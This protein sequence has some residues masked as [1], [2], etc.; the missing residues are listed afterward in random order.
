MNLPKEIRDIAA[1]LGHAGYQAYLVGG[2][3]RDLLMDK[4][5]AD[6][7]MATN[8]K[9]EEVQK[10]FASFAGGE[11]DH[12]DTVYENTFGT[13]GIKTGSSDPR[14][15]VV[16]VTT[17]RTE[18]AY[19]DKRHPDDVHFAE[20]IEEDLARRDF[21]INAMALPLTNDL[22]LVTDDQELELIDPYG[23]QEDLKKKIIRAVGDPEKR[24]SEDALRL[25]RA[26]RFAAQ[27]GFVIE[28][29]TRVAIR[30]LAP[31][32][33][34]I[35]KERIRDEFMKL[36]VTERAHEGVRE[37]LSTGLL[38]EIIP[39][40]VVGVGVEQNQHH[41]YDVFEHN[42]RSLEYAVSQNYSIVVRLASLLHDVGKPKSRRWKASAKAK[43]IRNGVRGDYTFYGH[44][45]VGARQTEAIL[46][47]L[48]FSR[49]IIDR[50]TLLVREHMFIYDPEV[51]TLAGV[52]RL[53]ARVGDENLEDLIRLREA[54]RI[55][56]GV[57]KAQPY[58]L[59]YLQA[60]LEKVQSD[61]VSPK[62]LA[63][64]GDEVIRIA[65]LT[66]GPRVGW[67]ISVLLD[68]VLEDPTRNSSEVLGARVAELAKL[69][70][71]ELRT[72]SEKGKKKALQAQE[73]IDEEI[74]KKYFV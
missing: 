56:S 17:F 63:M 39:E 50:V 36:L 28:E 62:M 9:P 12:P 43:K 38:Q 73:K 27:L 26:V 61:P 25:L 52:R 59:R 32:I 60:M 72:L 10:L 20:T 5:P 45:V 6:W 71:A 24:F 29:K 48:H 40:L 54:D 18:S 41:I 67:I 22:R 46:T 37:F 1:V 35:A 64:K 55:G 66:P 13:I 15:A 2:S 74:K 65:N 47:R 49:E 3:L 19:S 51:V 16:D 14:L 31:T 4:E 8:A 34:A 21:T 11:K 57:P 69:S 70:D 42:L 44:Q 68:E 7:D 23:G 30:K 33:S 58:R 53:R